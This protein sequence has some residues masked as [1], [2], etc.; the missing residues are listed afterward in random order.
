MLRASGRTVTNNGASAAA[1][2]TAVPALRLTTVA[3]DTADI[4]ILSTTREIGRVVR[5][6][7]NSASSLPSMSSRA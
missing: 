5:A 3:P 2:A 4:P 1:A 7:S 6:L